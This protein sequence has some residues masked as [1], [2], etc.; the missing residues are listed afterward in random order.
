MG[1]EDAEKVVGD[2]K[3]KGFSQIGAA[4]FC[5]GGK[6]AHKLVFSLFSNFLSMV[7]RFLLP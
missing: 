7:T 1:F 5:W 6:F 4:G 3:L 2:L